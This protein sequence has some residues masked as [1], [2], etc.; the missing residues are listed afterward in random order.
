MYT[1]LQSWWNNNREW[2][3]HTHTQTETDGQRDRRRGW[4]VQCMW[5]EREHGK[6]KTNREK[7]ISH[8]TIQSAVHKCTSKRMYESTKQT[9]RPERCRLSVERKTD[10]YTMRRSSLP[11]TQLLQQMKSHQVKSNQTKRNGNN[12]TRNHTTAKMGNKKSFVLCDFNKPR[13]T[14]HTHA[15]VVEL[16]RRCRRQPSINTTLLENH[17]E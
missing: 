17:I 7:R 3:K 11:H 12:G 5:N 6:T 13:Y 15:N 1:L 4:N 2:N 16:R 9:N 8:W 10:Y 14:P